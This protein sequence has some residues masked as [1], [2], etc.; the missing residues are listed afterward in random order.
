[1]IRLPAVGQYDTTNTHTTPRTKGGLMSKTERTCIM[2]EEA[3][4]RSKWV[5]APGKYNGKAMEGN[6]RVPQF[7]T[8]RNESRMPK[9]APP[10]GPGYYNPDF[11]S[12]ECAQPS[13]SD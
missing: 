13:Y 11:R 7:S 5:P 10:T 3:V 4:S 12:T 9:K 2:W 6:T 1:M 8:P